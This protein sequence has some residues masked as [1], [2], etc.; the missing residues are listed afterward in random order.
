MFRAEVTGEEALVAK[1]DAKAYGP[2]FHDFHKGVAQAGS[3]AGSRA[4]PRWSGQLA[5]SFDTA[6]EA[7]ALPEWSEITVGAPHARPVLGGSR[8]HMPPAQALAPM[9]GSLE[10]GFAIA[11]A[12]RRRGT[13]PHGFL[14][15]AIK[16]AA[17]AAS[18]GLNT[19]GR[20]IET[21]FGR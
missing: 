4:A 5:S 16:R 9:A 6:V 18:S 19:L 12:I 20:A 21:R 13:P 15:Q 3:D 1:L 14:G 11:H 7:S 17:S 2:D 10:G 8:P